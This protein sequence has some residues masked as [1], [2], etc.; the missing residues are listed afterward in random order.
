MVMHLD[1]NSCF[2][3]IEQQANPFLRG[4]PVAVV[5]YVSPGG[6]ILAASVEAKKLGVKTGMRV[7]EGKLLCPN[8]IVVGSDPNKYRSVH[9]QLRRLLEDYT[10]EVTPK[11]IDEFS[12]KFT[13]DLDLIKIAKEIKARIRSEIGDWLT[14]SVG[15]A[16]NCFLAKTAAGLHKPDGLDVI[17]ESNIREIFAK[18]KLIDLCGIKTNN[19]VRL[20]RAGIFTVLDFYQATPQTLQRAFCSIVGYYWYLR[21]HG[22]EPDETALGRRS[23]GNSYALPKP[24]STPEELAPILAKL[25]EKTG[26]RMRRGGYSACGVH[27][28]LL[29]RDGT[30]WHRGQKTPRLFDSRDIYKTAFKILESCPHRKPVHTLA[31]SCFNLEKTENCQLEIF[32]SRKEDLVRAMDRVNQRWGSFVIAPATM[33]GTSGLVPDRIAFGGVKE[34]EEVLLQ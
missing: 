22:G 19:A 11:S 30:F 5:A 8:L 4:K 29:Y 9:K 33:L 21:L 31:V 16:K 32:D 6:C 24:L 17:N 10:S 12:L 13:D 7:K 25:V 23:F 3:S 2:A 34:L 20:N 26:F 1:L 27:L 18:L 15:I 28:S 14:V